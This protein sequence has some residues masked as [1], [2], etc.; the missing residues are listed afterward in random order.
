MSTDAIRRLHQL[1]VNEP[2]EIIRDYNRLL[3]NVR[4]QHAFLL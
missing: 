1:R 2:H 4:V 3:H